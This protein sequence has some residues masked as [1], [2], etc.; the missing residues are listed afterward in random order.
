M[1]CGLQTG[2]F[3]GI[4][5]NTVHGS[6]QSRRCSGSKKRVHRDRAALGDCRGERSIVHAIRRV[7][8]SARCH[9]LDDPS[10]IGFSCRIVQTRLALPV[11]RHGKSLEQA[12]VGAEL[13]A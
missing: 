13:A 12:Q 5:P 3:E 6:E 1:A 9:K 2:I 11:A 4:G 10:R 7:N 8:I